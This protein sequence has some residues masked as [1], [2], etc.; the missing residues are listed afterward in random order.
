MS[1]SPLK[2]AAALFP[3]TTPETVAEAV[4]RVSG[5][6][7]RVLDVGCCGG[8]LGEF[9][10]A[11]GYELTGVDW[12]D[13]YL[14]T[15]KG[16]GYARTHKADLREPLNID[17]GPFPVVVASEVIEHMPDSSLEPMVRG[18][19]RHCSGHLVATVPDLDHPVSKVLDFVFFR[20]GWLDLFHMGEHHQ[21]F[22]RKTFAAL[23]ERCGFEV[24]S[25]GP[26]L[27]GTGMIVVARRR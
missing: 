27:G 4:E 2:F 18:L 11:R 23:L 22:T 19:H 21:R 25:A 6:D 17:G 9:L 3:L 1:F 16:R 12:D 15:A 24:L 20:R 13:Y 7:K 10:I 26:T 5:S 8:A 14:E